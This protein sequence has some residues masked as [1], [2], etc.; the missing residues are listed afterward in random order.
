[1]LPLTVLEPVKG[2][3]IELATLYDGLKPGRWLIVSGERTDVGIATGVRASERVM[4]SGVIQDVAKVKDA[5]GKDLE[6]PGDKVHTFLQL[7][8]LLKYQYKRDTVTLYGN[9]VK[10]THGETRTEVLGSGDGSQ[11]FQQFMLR[12]PPLTY[13]AA[14]TPI[15]AIGTLELRVNSLLWY[16]ADSLVG[17]KRSDRVYITKTDDASRTT[18]IFGNGT[19]GARLPTGMENIRATYRNGIGKTGNVKAEQI[20]LLASRPLGLKSVINPLPATGGANRESLDQ[21]RQN[22]PL[23]VMS[24]D[25]LV[26]VQDYADFTRTYAG[27]AKASAMPLSNGRRQVVHLTIAGS[28]DIPIDS[29]SD[30]YRNLYQ[31][32]QRYGD[33]LQP[34]QI[35]RRE[36]LLLLIS[37]NVKILPGY[38]WEDVAK[39]I[40][41]KLY[42]RFSFGH[43][44]LGQD[45]TLGDVI[46]IIQSVTIQRDPVVAYVDID[47]LDTVSETEAADP[48]RLVNK[49]SLLTQSAS[50][51]GEPSKQ[52]KTRITVNPAR[53]ETNPERRF[54]P[55]QLIQPAQLALLSSA[56]PETLILQEVKA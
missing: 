54:L 7:A 49:L 32:L 29:A 3:M 44:A 46:S 10:A 26:S 5:N 22:A 21:A 45:V 18:L 19:N 23:A 6:L 27:I 8:E 47:I 33:P 11:A 4:L 41:E 37:A 43:Q 42:Q 1:M 38:Q 48:T 39:E 50:A 13:L 2:S 14:P 36:L 12:Q 20:N 35:D 34:L 53:T 52:P 24:L 9:V 28:D 40:R 17:L 56:V 30:L 55:N 51:P 16:E 25:R 31:A 15:G